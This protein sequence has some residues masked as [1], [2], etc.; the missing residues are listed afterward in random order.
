MHRS[1]LRCGD[2]VAY[3]DTDG[4]DAGTVVGTRGKLE[5][6]WDIAQPIATGEIDEVDGFYPPD[7]NEVGDRGR[8]V[9]FEDGSLFVERLSK[10]STR[11]QRFRWERAAR[12]RLINALERDER[13]SAILAWRTRHGLPTSE[14]RPGTA[15][16]ERMVEVLTGGVTDDDVEGGP[17]AWAESLA[18]G[19]CACEEGTLPGES[20]DDEET[21]GGLGST[22]PED[23]CL[24]CQA[25][26]LL[27][28]LDGR[29][30]GETV[31]NLRAWETSPSCRPGI[32]YPRGG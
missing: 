10:D 9:G 29:E 14:L 31:L 15:V 1:R 20:V 11:S 2:R 21:S 13:R 12:V 4:R 32:S 25:L 18:G 28:A 26:S 3:P 6:V 5:V 17:V 30:A 27:D 16:V 19:D 23:W 7:V 24:R 8:L 22:E